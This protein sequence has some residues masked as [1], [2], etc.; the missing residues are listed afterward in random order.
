MFSIHPGKCPSPDDYNCWSMWQIRTRA[1]ALFTSFEERGRKGK[2]RKGERRENLP[3]VW[4]L[5][6]PTKKGDG[7]LM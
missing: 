5:K 7:G 1:K 2:E 4:D 3:L 6:K